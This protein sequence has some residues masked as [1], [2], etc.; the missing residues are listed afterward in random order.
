[1]TRLIDLFFVCVFAAIAVGCVVVYL[2]TK[3]ERTDLFIYGVCSYVLFIVMLKEYRKHIQ[4][5]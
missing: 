5:A 4:E 1:M 3:I 2:I